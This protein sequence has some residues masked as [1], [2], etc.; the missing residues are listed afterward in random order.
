MTNE[1]LAKLIDNLNAGEMKKWASIFDLSEKVQKSEI[2][3]NPPDGVAFNESSY[4]FFLVREGGE[5]VG[6][7]LD[8]VCDLHALTKED[9]RGRG[10]MTRALKE[11]IFPWLYQNGRKVQK[12]TFED[13]DYSVRKLGFTRNGNA[14]TAVLDLAIYKDVPKIMATR[15]KLTDDQLVDLKETIRKSRAYLQIAKEKLAAAYGDAVANLGIDDELDSLSNL[16]F[17]AEEFV[18]EHRP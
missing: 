2:W 7:V 13:P 4:S 12:V 8:M 10:Y 14:Y 6:V 15:H 17:Q 16:V 18:L 5:Y 3:V 9:H 1:L 11:C